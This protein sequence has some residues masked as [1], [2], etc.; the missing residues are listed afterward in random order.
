M[1]ASSMMTAAHATARSIRS[2]YATYAEALRV[3]MLAQ[4]QLAREPVAEVVV[5][6]AAC[7]P[8]VAAA[9]KVEAKVVVIRGSFAHLSR[10][11]HCAKHLP[12]GTWADRT[13]DGDLILDQDGRWMIHTSDGFARKATEYVVVRDGELKSSLGRRFKE[14]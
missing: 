7:P 1:T 4:W 8:V 9:A 13:D 14:V 12:T 6:Q 2:E 11:K 5:T 10:G 3:A